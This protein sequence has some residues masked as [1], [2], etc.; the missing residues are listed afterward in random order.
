M[1]QERRSFQG[2]LTH[3]CLDCL[4]T[5]NVACLL[6]QVMGLSRLLSKT[7]LIILRKAQSPHV[8]A[9][10]SC[11]HPYATCPYSRRYCAQII[12][13]GAI[14]L[15]PYNCFSHRN[16]QS[17]FSVSRL[18]LTTHRAADLMPT[19]RSTKGCSGSHEELMPKSLL[20]ICS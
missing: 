14:L 12:R 13:V 8:S 11:L 1:P 15:S 5:Q 7:P 17:I 20:L 2:V 18:S 19:L 4:I 10:C 6:P 3:T 16:S 9:S